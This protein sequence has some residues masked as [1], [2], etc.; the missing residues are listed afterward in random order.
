MKN[1]KKRKNR[2]PKARLRYGSGYK[3]LALA[4]CKGDGRLVRLLFG[5]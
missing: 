5:N 1:G 4:I 2:N 3:G